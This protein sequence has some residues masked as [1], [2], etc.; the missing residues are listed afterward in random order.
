VSHCQNLD[1][2]DYRRAGIQRDGLP[3]RPDDK[4]VSQRAFE[5]RDKAVGNLQGSR[6]ALV[7]NHHHQVRGGTH[8]R[9]DV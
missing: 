5:H 8:R 9:A 1:V 4:G 6:H 3:R 7:Y 2:A